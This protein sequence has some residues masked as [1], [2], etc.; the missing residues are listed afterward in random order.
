MAH[1]DFTLRVESG[2]DRAGQ[3]IPRRFYLGSRPVQ[4]D[5]VI[6]RW[7]GDDRSYYK[8]RGDDGDV[9]ILLREWA[10]ER[11]Q[12]HWELTLFTSASLDAAPSC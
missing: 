8:V 10:A 4:V 6:D 1:G 3:A 11:A 12:E 7:L 2:A 5:E 9:Y